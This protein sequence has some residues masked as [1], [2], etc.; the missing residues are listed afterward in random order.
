MEISISISVSVSV[1]RRV[2]DDSSFV[3]ITGE[4]VLR[5]QCRLALNGFLLHR[6]SFGFEFDWMDGWMDGWMAMG[7]VKYQSSKEECLRVRR[8]VRI[9]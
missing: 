6:G 2:S 3:V 4:S 9:I 1:V 7:R 5:A 8:H